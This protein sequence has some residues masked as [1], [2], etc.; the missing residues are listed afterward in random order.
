MFSTIIERLEVI[1]REYGALGVFWAAF[2]EEIIAPIPSS[3]IAMMSGFF[4]LETNL[5]WGEALGQGFLLVAIPM[6]LGMTVGSI[7][8]YGACYYGGKPFIERYGK[9]LS[10]SWE[11]IERAEK[12]FTKGRWDELSM[13]GARILP[14]VP[15]VAISS[16]SGLIR[17]PIKTFIVLSLIGG[18]IRSLIMGLI[19]WQARDA[20]KLYAER[21][22]HFESISTLIVGVLCLGALAYWFYKKKKKEKKRID[23]EER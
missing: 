9:W 2:T 7:I 10:I 20:Y 3:F 22:E 23:Q 13:L 15:S 1:I 16:F 17:Y 6:A 4:L 14:I 21:F 8:I 5:T 12:K 18:A 19:G 11:G